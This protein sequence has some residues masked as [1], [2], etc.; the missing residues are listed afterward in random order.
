MT[1]V[2]QVADIDMA[3]YLN[4]YFSL[5][6]D[7]TVQ[8]QECSMIRFE[9]PLPATNLFFSRQKNA[10]FLSVRDEE[11]PMNADKFQALSI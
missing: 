6:T 1:G 4:D 2:E 10:R 3:L 9:V 8:F 7:S 5:A 11:N